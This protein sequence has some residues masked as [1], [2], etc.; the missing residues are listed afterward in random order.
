[1]ASQSWLLHEKPHDVSL[2]KDWL[3]KWRSAWS[4]WLL[5]A[6]CGGSDMQ[7]CHAGYAG[8]YEVKCN[9]HSGVRFTWQNSFYHSGK[10][11]SITDKSQTIAPTHILL[12]ALRGSE[13]S[14]CRCSPGASH[15]RRPV[16]VIPAEC[17]P[18][19]IRKDLPLAVL[20]VLAQHH[21][22]AQIVLPH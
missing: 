12:Y 15:K 8:F 6:S 22:T 5:R 20:E 11:L 4:G 1:M 7:F 2:V 16:N 14:E 9:H 21:T 3:Q 13:H 17:R 18:L 19:L 10:Q